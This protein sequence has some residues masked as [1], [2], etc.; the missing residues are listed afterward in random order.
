VPLYTATGSLY[1]Y[2]CVTVTVLHTHHKELQEGIPGGVPGILGV[3]ADTALDHRVLAHEDHGIGRRTSPDVLELLGPHIVSRRDEGLVVL[4]PGRSTPALKDTV[5]GEADSRELV[6]GPQ[7]QRRSH[8]E[9]VTGPCYTR[10]GRST[11]A[12]MG[13]VTEQHSHMGSVT[14]PQSQ[15]HSHR[16]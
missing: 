5:T 15:G 12:L 9:S 11:P 1:T 13:K 14:G 8:R 10:P 4:G 7:S 3:L 2:T 16:E 6:T